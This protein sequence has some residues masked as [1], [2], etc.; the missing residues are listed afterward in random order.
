MSLRTPR[1]EL[2]CSCD[3]PISGMIQLAGVARLGSIMIGGDIDVESLA[4]SI[5]EVGIFTSASDL[6]RA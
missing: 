4:A 5:G 3:G 2:G 6:L 1:C